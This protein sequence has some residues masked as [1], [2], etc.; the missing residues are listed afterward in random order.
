MTFDKIIVMACE[1]DPQTTTTSTTTDEGTTTTSTTTDE[2]TTTSTTTECGCV[3]HVTYITKVQ[4]G[5]GGVFIDVGS[6]EYP[7]GTW[8]MRYTLAANGITR[9]TTLLNI[10]G[11]T[12][13]GFVG[14]VGDSVEFNRC[15][16][17]TTSTTT[18]MII[19]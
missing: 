14:A 13:Y 8:F 11:P 18:E 10:T 15:S 7:I 3:D 6:P 17:G 19:G 16:D 5:P 2:G 4:S 1:N 9:C 12:Q